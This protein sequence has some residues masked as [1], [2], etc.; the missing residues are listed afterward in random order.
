MT[1][2]YGSAQL[3][4]LMPVPAENPET[5]GPLARIRF[6]RCLGCH[7]GWHWDRGEPKRCGFCVA[8][9]DGNT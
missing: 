2:Q 8:R 9:K 1:R 3:A 5:H 4:D 7:R 6:F